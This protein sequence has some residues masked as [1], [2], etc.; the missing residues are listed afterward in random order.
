MGFYNGYNRGYR[1][2][3]GGSYSRGVSYNGGGYR[4]GSV[5]KRSGC[6]VVERDGKV[7]VSAWRKNSKGF[8]SL[9]AR[10]YSKTKEVQSGR[11]TTWLNLFVTIVN[12][13]TMQVVKTSGMYDV[14]KQRLYIKEFNLI[15]S[16]RGG[17]GGY[18]GR[19][20]GKRRN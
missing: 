5:R 2:G 10:P 12:R 20:L 19:H 6:R 1:G 11:G 8:Y 4:S 14:E 16:A 15:A 13:D 7:F 3:Y 18:F 17:V 9:Y